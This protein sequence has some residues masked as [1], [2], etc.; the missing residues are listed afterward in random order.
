MSPNLGKVFVNSKMRREFKWWKSH[1]IWQ[2]KL[3]KNLSTTKS[4]K[5]L[6]KCW[7]NVKVRVDII[8]DIFD[9]DGD[10]EKMDEK[11]WKEFYLGHSWSC[12]GGGGHL[13][14]LNRVPGGGHLDNLWSNQWRW[15]WF[16]RKKFTL[17][18]NSIEDVGGD[19]KKI[20]ILWQKH[21]SW[22]R[23]Y[24]GGCDLG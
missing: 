10:D 11:L 6:R 1:Q 18:K 2:W 14:C 13:R 17:D 8:Y 20:K 15:W 21:L 9:V 16:W 23:F 19:E 12:W 4:P 7:W 3:W 22:R 5:T 24:I